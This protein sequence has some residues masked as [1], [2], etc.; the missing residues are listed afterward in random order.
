MTADDAIALAITKGCEVKIRGREQCVIVLVEQRKGDSIWFAER[1]LTSE[2]VRD[3][4][5]SLIGYGVKECIEEIERNQRSCPS[6]R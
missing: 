1:Q 2:A 5:V 3:A 4:A 6:P